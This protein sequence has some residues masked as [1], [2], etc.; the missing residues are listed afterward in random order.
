MAFL[1]KTALIVVVCISCG[2]L[3]LTAIGCGLEQG[4]Y[5][6]ADGSEYVGQLKNGKPHG[7]GT[8]IE[9]T[10]S[11]EYVGQFKD[12]KFHG[13]GTYIH[14]GV[15]GNFKI[16]YVGE[17]KEDYLMKYVGEWKDDKKHGQG[18]FTWSDGR[19]YVGGWKDDEFHGQGAYTYADGT[20]EEGRWENDVC[21]VE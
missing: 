10:G 4:T 12:G 18:T 16:T 2:I 13:K 20:V 6:Y 1:K 9:F 3:F 14:T 8:K 21:I 17:S 7:Q 11:G 19:K 15:I 5:T